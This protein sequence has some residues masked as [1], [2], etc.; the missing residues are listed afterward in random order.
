[1]LQSVR[2]WV[3]LHPSGTGK[4]TPTTTSGSTRRDQSTVTLQLHARPMTPGVKVCPAAHPTTTP[5][6]STVALLPCLQTTAP[7]RR[8]TQR[9]QWTQATTA[10]LVRLRPR[11]RTEMSA[12]MPSSLTSLLPHWTMSITQRSAMMQEPYLLARW[13]C[14][15]C[16][17]T[18][19][20]AMGLDTPTLATASKPVIARTQTQLT[21]LLRRSKGQV[22]TV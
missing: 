4:E 12:S 17:S 21:R 20:A 15:A 14:S 7:S 5:L 10:L 16:S 22:P 2:T 3:C 1:M 8:S 18:I 6:S 19:S 11:A 13:A 9:E